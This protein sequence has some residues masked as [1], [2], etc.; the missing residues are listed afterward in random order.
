MLDLVGIDKNKIISELIIRLE[1]FEGR[2]LELE[3]E[4]AELREG[5]SNYEN[6]KNSRNSSTPHSKDE[7]RPKK[8][9][10]LCRATGRK[11]GGQPGS[12]GNT[13]KMTADPDH[14]IEL[15]P[16]YCRNCGSALGHLPSIRERARQIV[17]IPP[18]R[19]VWTEYRTY[20]RQQGL[21]FNI[22]NKELVVL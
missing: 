13:L 15:R 7:N 1:R 16:D 19:V 6:P 14:V 2:V 10:S 20:G 22:M 5:L 3:R 11:P 17:D 4:N 12:K 21:W 9:Q 8:N 18:V